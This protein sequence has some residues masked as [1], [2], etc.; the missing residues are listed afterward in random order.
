MS[1]EDDVNYL[2][3]I[4]FANGIVKVG[5]TNDIR[6]RYKDHKRW[7]RQS[8]TTIDEIDFSFRYGT[9]GPDERRLI[10]FCRD[11]WDNLP[12]HTEHFLEA[13]FDEVFTYF[14]A[15]ENVASAS[16]WRSEIS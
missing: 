15:L 3:V 10:R 12:G 4:R 2:Y 1:N 13:D 7:A 8:G 16:G 9:A 5:R 14:R 11:R 6:R